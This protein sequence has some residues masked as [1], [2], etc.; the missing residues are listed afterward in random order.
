MNFIN[1][2]KENILK[3][4][5]KRV[6]KSPLPNNL[7]KKPIVEPNNFIMKKDK[8][9]KM[10]EKLERKKLKAKRSNEYIPVVYEIPKELKALLHRS[11]EIGIREPMF[12]KPKEFK[13]KGNG[14]NSKI[15]RDNDKVRYDRKN[16][17]HPEIDNQIGRASCRERVSSPV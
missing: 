9:D 8:A 6:S 13:P 14:R 4:Q 12:D 17:Y 15:H 2:N 7:I 16:M 1:Y 11:P 5:D 10:I 3:F